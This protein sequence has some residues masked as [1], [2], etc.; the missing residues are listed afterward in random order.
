MLRL[1]TPSA[2]LGHRYQKPKGEKT[3]SGCPNVIVC[4]K[5]DLLGRILQLGHQIFNT[6]RSAMW[7]GKFMGVL[8]V[9]HPLHR[10]KERVNRQSPKTGE[11]VRTSPSVQYPSVS[12]LKNPYSLF[13]SLSQS[14]T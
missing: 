5:K 14:S 6:V 9:F 11:D 2:P 1:H 8:R 4:R 10:L 12:V 13:V 3:K 7:W